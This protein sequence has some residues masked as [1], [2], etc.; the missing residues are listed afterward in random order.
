MK[1]YFIIIFCSITCCFVFL[2]L[3]VRLSIV[4]MTIY[5]LYIYSRGGNVLFTRR[6]NQ[7]AVSEKFLVHQ[8]KLLWGL[9]FS[10]KDLVGQIAVNKKDDNASEPF[11]SFSTPD[12]KV[13][14]LELADGLRFVMTTDVN[15]NKMQDALNYIYKLYVDYCVKNPMYEVGE[16]ITCASFAQKTEQWIQGLTIFQ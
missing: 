4:A 14:Y 1:C 5:N 11:Y 7:R 9:L 3:L 2:L 15:V 13:H 12:Y 10:M 6:W 16:A 8:Q